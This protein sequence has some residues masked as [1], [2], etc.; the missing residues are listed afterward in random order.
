M[1][2]K[3]YT[4]QKLVKIN[5]HFYVNKHQKKIKM[6]EKIEVVQNNFEIESFERAC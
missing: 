2:V 5:D 1:V 6:H 3:E 4:K